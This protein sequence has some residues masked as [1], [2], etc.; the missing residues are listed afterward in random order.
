LA[1]ILVVSYCVFE[2]A[3]DD[4]YIA[5]YYVIALFKYVGTG[6][7]AGFVNDLAFD[8]FLLENVFFR[9]FIRRGDAEPRTVQSQ[10]SIV[11]AEC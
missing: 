3:E 11:P 2:A 8:D 7:Y 4:P 5:A 9:L 6:F 10:S 1:F